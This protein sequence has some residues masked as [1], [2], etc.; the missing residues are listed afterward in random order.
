VIEKIT[1]IQKKCSR[2]GVKKQQEEA[3]DGI[4]D[5]WKKGKAIADY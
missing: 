3:D 1:G 2:R 5:G 4:M